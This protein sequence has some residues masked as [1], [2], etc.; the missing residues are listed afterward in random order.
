[1]KLNSSIENIKIGFNCSKDWDGMD[2]IPFRKKHC[3]SCNKTVT[4]FT[5]F[6]ETEII[7]YFEGG[8]NRNSCGR[9]GDL[10]LSQ[11]NRKLAPEKKTS[12]AKYVAPL[13]LGTLLSNAACQT[14]EEICPSSEVNIHEPE[15]A[16]IEQDINK[17]SLSN[18][19]IHEPGYTIIEQDIN[20]DSL[21]STKIKGIVV[22]Q[23]NQPTIG[24]TVCISGTSLG[25]VS[26]WDGSFE[27]E[28]AKENNFNTLEVRYLGY[29]TLIIHL[30]EIT[31]NEIR[32]VI[33]ESR[34]NV[35][36]S[37]KFQTPMGDVTLGI[38]IITE[39]VPWHKR[40]W[41]KMSRRRNR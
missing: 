5:Q 7:Q 35:V 20:K 41:R 24:A 12:L 3:Q 26:D 25:V 9:F 6:T 17:D 38:M 27:L 39:P 36:H 2:E 13:L 1:M 10:Q 18:I 11:L 29:E 16:I 31:N 19:K 28:I 34:A 32:I 8:K 33:K 4:D 40:V 30:A 21:S 23:N 37:G 22:N 15:Y 14:T